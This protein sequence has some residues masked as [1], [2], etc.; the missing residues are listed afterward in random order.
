MFCIP[1]IQFIANPSVNSLQIFVRSYLPS[2]LRWQIF[3]SVLNS[4]SPISASRLD[5]TA[6][7]HCRLFIGPTD[8]DKPGLTDMHHLWHCQLGVTDENESALPISIPRKHFAICILHICS[9]FTRWFLS[10]TSILNYMLL[11]NMTQGPNLLDP[12]SRR[13]FLGNWC[14]RGRESTSKLIT[15]E[16]KHI[17]ASPDA[18]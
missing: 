4:V 6:T 17:L 16:R 1:C 7:L 18:Y 12:C 2:E 10:S 13:T 14:Q 9:S 3:S 5:R 8:K 11:C 15:W